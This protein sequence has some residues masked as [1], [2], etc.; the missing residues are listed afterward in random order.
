MAGSSGTGITGTNN[1]F[2]LD[3]GHLIADQGLIPEE[4]ADGKTIY[5]API[6]VQLVYAV[7]T[8]S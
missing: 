4:L 2:V 8:V 3:F 5:N 7:S 1:G 6:D